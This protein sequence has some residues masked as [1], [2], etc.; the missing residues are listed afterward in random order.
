MTACTQASPPTQSP[1]TAA[2]SGGTLR[3]VMP[4]DSTAFGAFTDPEIYDLALDPHW[5]WPAPHDT[6][7]L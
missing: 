2:F 6:G 4:G 3:V 7:E 1:S 5:D